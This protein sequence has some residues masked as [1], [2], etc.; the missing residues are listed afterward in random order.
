MTRLV[1]VNGQPAVE[2]LPTPRPRIIVTQTPGVGPPGPPGSAGA[3]V[4][5]TAGLAISS[6][7]L[8]TV[9]AGTAVYFD[10]DDPAILGRVTGISLTSATIGNPVTIATGGPVTVAGWGLTPG[11]P[12][13]AG[14][15]GT[16]TPFGG[17]APGA[18]VVH[19]GHTIS[20]DTLIL[21]VTQHVERT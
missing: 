19:V 16:V 20:T 15:N 3:N 4:T 8:I 1:I 6:G 2:I 21:A 7:R 9:T 5:A 14:P 13:F 17:V 12:Y 11:S 10:A 18:A